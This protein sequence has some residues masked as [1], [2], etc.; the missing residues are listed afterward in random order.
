MSSMTAKE[1]ARTSERRRGAPRARPRTASASGTPS[2]GTPGKSSQKSRIG[3]DW[4][5]LLRRLR[6]WR[7][8]ARTALGKLNAVP[9]AV[10][11]IAIAAVALGLFSVTN[12]VYHVLRK[13][14]EMFFPVSGALNKMPAETWRQYAPLFKEYSTATITPE[15][16]AALAQV[17]SA[18]NPV[19]RTYWRWRLTWHP[20]EIYQPASSAVGMYQ[21]T[22][23]AF[24][25]ARHYCIRHHAVVKEGAWND[26]NSCWFNRF[27]SR[28]MPSH[29]IELTAVSL[30][31]NVVEILA[32]RP[33]AAVSSQQTQ[34]LAAIAHLCGAGPAAAFA[35]R[36]FQLMPD[37][38]CGDHDVAIYLARVNAMKRQFQRLIAEM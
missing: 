37:E 1:K 13:P 25:D 31:R 38:R 19:A 27:Y 23:A 32:R 5:T 22:D 14:T 21:L 30:D 34:D 2:S 29:A 16:L 18:G 35:R 26:W 3:H 17:E 4:N 10:R 7:K 15:L 33:S 20:F 9:P 12:F 8:R 6:C 24:A 11:T 36:G 28:V